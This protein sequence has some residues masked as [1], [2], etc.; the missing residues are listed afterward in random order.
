MKRM[1]LVATGVL[2][3]A[4][5]AAHPSV[6]AHEHPHAVS[7]LPDFAALL[8]AAVAVGAG[9]LIFAKFREFGK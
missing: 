6:V 9:V 2:L 4:L 1:I 8:M 3:P 7:M 5:A